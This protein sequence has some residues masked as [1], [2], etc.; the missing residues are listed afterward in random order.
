MKE[1]RLQSCREKSMKIQPMQNAFRLNNLDQRQVF[2]NSPLFFPATLAESD[3]SLSTEDDDQLVFMDEDCDTDQQ[4]ALQKTPW[5]ILIADDDYNV[6]ETTI[7][8]L[9]GA[10]IHGRPL[11]F[12]HAY[13]AHEARDIIEKSPDLALV[14]LDVV[15]ETVDAGLL[16]VNT[17]RNELAKPDLRI[18]LRTG[19]PGYA[20][21]IEV[22]KNYAIDGYT[23][24][25]KLT[26]SL[27]L[28][29]LSDTL[30]PEKS[31]HGGYSN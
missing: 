25:A 7:L 16:L 12:L 19:Q 2:G 1:S 10:A 30:A 6:H 15:M 31:E 18:V 17:I 27:L 21:E 23:T 9:H 13:S 4:N 3:I 11:Q 26:R 20:P 24:K 28:S 5:L 29:V 8:A 14:L 22:N